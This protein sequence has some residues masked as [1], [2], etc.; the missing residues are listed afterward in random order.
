MRENLIRA[1]CSLLLCAGCSGELPQGSVSP[2]ARTDIVESLREDETLARHP[3]D[4]GGRAWLEVG[5]GLSASVSAGLPGRWIVVYEAGPLGVAEG[6]WVFLQ[7]SPFWGWSTP[8]VVDPDYI[9]YTEVSTEA[10]GVVLEPDTVDEQLLAIRIAG[11]ALREGERI[12]I[13]YGAGSAGALADRYAERR[14]RFYLAVDGDGDGI[15]AVVPDALEVDVTPGPAARLV[16]TLP[17]TARPGD[18]VRLTLAL[19]DYVG[20]AGVEASG[21]FRLR[22]DALALGLPSSL[23]I[24][25]ADG[26]VVSIDVSNPTEGIYRIEAEGPGGILGESNP[27]VVSRNEPRILW[28]DLHGHSNLSDG[29]GTPKDYFRY[30][31]DVAALDVVA[32]T[33]HDHWGLRALDRNPELW[34]EIRRETQLFHQPGRFVTLLGYEWTNRIH[35]HRHVLY[36]R[37]HGEVLSAIDPA[38]ETPLQLWDALRGQE[39]LT[40]AHHSAGGPVATNWDFPPDPDLEPVTEIVSVHGSS[41]AL[42]SPTPIYRPVEGNFVRDVLNRGYVLGFL[43]SG[44]GHDGHPGLSGLAAASGGLAAILSEELTRQGVMAALRERRV[45]ATNGPRILLRVALAGQPMGSRLSVSEVQSEASGEAT[46]WVR[47]VAPAALQQVDLIRRGASVE[48]LSCEGQRSCEVVWSIR[49]LES[50]DFLYLR[51]V[52][53]DGGAAWSSPFF[54][55]P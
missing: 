32:L 55:E 54:I 26:G 12:R 24:R 51:V 19:V 50:G 46:L 17:S 52:Q 5:E 42:D 23:P 37:D 1:L 34:E 20:N 13:D 10:E 8:Q 16:V 30:A 40:F 25:P 7:V 43:G 27:L 22:G 6:G 38:F 11:R 47:S 28:G 49:G 9:G 14:S 31:R 53:V 35:G 45:Y 36:F 44:D 21:E 29:T 3:A 33:D 18:T 39:V 15:R 41:E 48:S 2:T 4:G